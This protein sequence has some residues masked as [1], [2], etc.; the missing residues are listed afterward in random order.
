M[1]SVLVTGGAG[2]IGSHLCKKLLNEGYKVVSY[3][4]FNDFYAP[5]NKEL[6]I[7]ALNKFENF[8]SIK[9]DIRDLDKLN[10]I[11]TEYKIDTVVHLAAMAGVRPSIEDPLEY[12]SVNVHGFQCILESCKLNKI[13]HLIAASSSSVYGNNKK[14]PFSETDNVDFAISPYAATKKSNEVMAHVYHKLY[15]LNTI[16]LRFFTVYGPGQRPDLAIH[17]FTNLIAQDKPIPFYGDGTTRRDYT[18]VEDIVEG[19]FSSMNY[20]YQKESCYE[21]INL[22]N[23]YPVD[24]N[25]MVSTIEKY[26]QKKAVLNKFDL[27]PGDVNQTYADIQKAQKLLNYSP[28]TTFDEGIEKFVAWYNERDEKYQS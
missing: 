26:I 11:I 10:T 23:N 22:G 25:T 9:A 14:V 28:K 24:L 16:M 6:N 5:I 17:K 18:Y 7:N 8:L 20:S 21:I 3:D 1:K 27:P 4:N 15:D 2:F 13:K 12:E 19:I